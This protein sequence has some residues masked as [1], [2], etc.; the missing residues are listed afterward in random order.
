MSIRMG[1]ACIVTLIISSISVIFLGP[2]GILIY[3]IGFYAVLI[4]VFLKAR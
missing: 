1:I 4:I 2:L 3:G